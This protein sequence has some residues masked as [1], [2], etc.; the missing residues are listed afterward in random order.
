MKCLL[1]KLGITDRESL[2][3]V[4][5]Q[6]IKFGVVGLSNTAISLAL[7]YLFV[8]INPN[9]YMVGNVVGFIVSVANAFF[10]SRR[11][12]FTGGKESF[13]KGLLKSYIAY[14]GSFLL[15]TGLLFLQV[16]KLG[17][18]REIAPILN[19]LITIPLNF[20]VNKFWTFQTR[21]AG[22]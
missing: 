21:E 16:E 9:L 6:F 10:W 11:Y 18:S 20:L 7:Y 5:I 8:W 17:V 19:L 3:R 13:M 4:C 12:V 15:A 1:A 2:W 22:K 14:G